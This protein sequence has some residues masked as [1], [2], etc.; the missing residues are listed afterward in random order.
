L[1]EAFFRKYI[2]LH[3]YIKMQVKQMSLLFVNSEMVSCFL[4][5]CVLIRTRGQEYITPVLRSLHWLPVRF[6]IDF[7]ILLAVYKCFNGLGPSYLSDLLLNYEPSWTL[8]F[9]GKGLLVV[10]KVRTKT[11]TGETLF[12]YYGP[13]LWNSLPENIRAA[14]TVDVFKKRLKTYLFNLAF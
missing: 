10:P 2:H 8:R 14:E 12:R 5:R 9:S 11:K 7:K 13:C 3:Y 4:V 1:G 6:R